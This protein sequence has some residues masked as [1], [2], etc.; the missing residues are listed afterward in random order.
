MQAIRK[1]RYMV[2]QQD[3]EKG[4]EVHVKKRDVDF[5]FYK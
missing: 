5:E 1:N 4:Y 3:F 2:L